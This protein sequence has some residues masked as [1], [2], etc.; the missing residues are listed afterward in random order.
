MTTVSNGSLSVTGAATLSGTA[1][2]NSAAT[3]ATGGLT[4]TG[5]INF[6]GTGNVITGPI[7]NAGGTITSQN[8]TPFDT[9]DRLTV[10]SVADGTINLQTDFTNSVSDQVTI[11]NAGGGTGTITLNFDPGTTPTN[12][13]TTP[14]DAIN[15]SGLSTSVFALGNGASLNSTLITYALSDADGSIDLIG[16]VDPGVAALAGNVSLVQTLIGSVINRPSSPFVSGLAYDD[17]DACG[18]GAWTRAQGGYANAEARTSNGVSNLPATV[19]SKFS[20]LQF[21]GDFGC[22]NAAAGGFDLAYGGVV[23][24][25]SGSATQDVFPVDPANPTQFIAGAAATS[26]TETDFDQTFVGG[27]VAFAKGPWS[28]DVQVRLDKTKFEFNNASI[29]LLGSEADSNSQT[30]SG[31]ISYAVPFRDSW[32]FVPTAGLGLTWSETD[33]IKFTDPSGANI[34]VLQSDDHLTKVGFVGATVA[35]TQIGE[36]GDSAI[37]RFATATIYNEFSDARESQFFFTDAAGTPT[38]NGQTFSTENLDTFGELSLGMSYIKILDG[39]VGNAKQLNASVR[40]D[41][42][43]SDRVDSVSLTAQARLQF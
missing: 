33:D 22:F 26:T 38:G 31:S 8:N 28:G 24:F 11:A 40:L 29:S 13:I 14:I 43:F 10:D 39:Q 6:D 5:T 34:A 17:E 20:G 25:N 19:E 1:T 23:G 18:Q 42:R 12:Q 3:L 21:G 7:N 4:N 16:Q 41:T 32:T 35:N 30:L 37:S 9:A 36:A 15:G 27:Y 2:L